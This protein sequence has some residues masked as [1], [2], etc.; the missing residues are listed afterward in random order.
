VLAFEVKDYNVMVQKAATLPGADVANHLLEVEGRF[1][2]MLV[3][4]L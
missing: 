3:R 4:L 1:V 2:I